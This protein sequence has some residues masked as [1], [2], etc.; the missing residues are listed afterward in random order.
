MFDAWKKW[1]N[2]YLNGG[3][4]VIYHG[5]SKKSPYLKKNQEY[6]NPSFGWSKI[7]QE[8]SDNL[9]SK[10]TARFSTFAKRM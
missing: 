6:S 3:L 9:I 5:T 2:I 7:P 4:M 10:A 1:K 8:E